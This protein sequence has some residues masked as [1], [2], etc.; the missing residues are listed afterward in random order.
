MKII[1]VIHSA[2]TIWNFKSLEYYDI[3]PD[4]IL[5]DNDKL[6]YPANVEIRRLKKFVKPYTSR[7]LLDYSKYLEN[8]LRDHFKM[9][10]RIFVHTSKELISNFIIHN[11]KGKVEYVDEGLGSY[12]GFSLKHE[13]FCV[14]INAFLKLFKIRF[15]REYRLLGLKRYISRFYLDYPLLFRAKEYQDILEIPKMNPS[16]KVRLKD[17]NIVYF[18]QD[19]AFFEPHDVKAKEIL[20][21]LR[22]HYNIY[23]RNHY[24]RKSFKTDPGSENLVGDIREIDFKKSL[25]VLTCASSVILDIKKYYP[26]TRIILLLKP[27]EIV[28]NRNILKFVDE[29]IIV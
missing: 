17:K 3:Y 13:L 20:N 15:T 2:H 19:L 28:R 25:A 21:K 6:R 26:N 8:S 27:I 16:N 14:A 10:V 1:F 4:L 12:S 18:N 11:C 7:R 24:L 9:D 23:V 22:G 5:T 29:I